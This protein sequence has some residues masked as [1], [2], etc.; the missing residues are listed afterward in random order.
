MS[1][2]AHS[3][4]LISHKKPFSRSLGLAVIYFYSTFTSLDNAF[5]HVYLPLL[6][7]ALCE[8]KGQPILL[9]ANSVTSNTTQSIT[10]W[11]PSSTSFDLSSRTIFLATKY[12]CNMQY[13]T[14]IHTYAQIHVRK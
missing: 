2:L 7:L 8:F 10:F 1:L 9:T 12:R 14:Y 3:L 11:I 4:N 6:G 13:I 5:L